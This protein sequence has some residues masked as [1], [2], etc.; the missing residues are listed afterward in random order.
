MPCYDCSDCDE[1]VCCDCGDSFDDCECSS[2][3]G[4]IQA[5]LAKKPKTTAPHVGVEL[6]FLAP[7]NRDQ[8][9]Q[10][11]EEAGLGEYC[12]IKGDESVFDRNGSL[13]GH[14]LNVLCT[15]RNHRRVL[16][17]VCRMFRAMG[18]TVNRTCGMHIHLD[19]RRRNKERV[20]SNLVGSQ[21][22]LMQ[23]QP[24]SRQSNSYCNVNPDRNWESARYSGRNAVNAGAYSVHQTI[25]IRM[26]SGTINFKKITNWI[27]ILLKIAKKRTVME[28][29]QTRQQLTSALRLSPELRDYM[30]ERIEAFNPPEENPA[31]DAIVA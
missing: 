20:F 25:E 30:K 31:D 12:L 23:M 22:V 27:A 3:R 15:E 29:V 21:E 2:N 9:A 6:E 28:T 17:K 16:R 1:A 4:L 26:H 11:I 14:E 8:V 18:A 7:L 24:R 5:F 10:K 13:R 19:M